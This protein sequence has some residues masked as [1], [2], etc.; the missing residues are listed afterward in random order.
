MRQRFLD[1]PFIM[2]LSWL[3]PLRRL[4]GGLWAKGRRG[5]WWTPWLPYDPYLVGPNE[6]WLL[7]SMQ[8]NWHIEDYR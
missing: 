1:S 8:E 7:D 3:K 5:P 4:L 2:F 6:K